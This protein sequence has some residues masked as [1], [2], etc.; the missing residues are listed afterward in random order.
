MI[1]CFIFRE[2]PNF[3]SAS[4]SAT[5]L[6]SSSFASHC[7]FFFFRFEG[8]QRISCSSSFARPLFCLFKIKENAKKSSSQTIVSVVL[9]TL[10]VLRSFLLLIFSLAPHL[11]ARP[12]FFL[13]TLFK[14]KKENAKSLLSKQLSVGPSPWQSFDH[15]SC[16]SFFPVSSLGKKPERKRQR[17][18][19][20]LRCP[21]FARFLFVAVIFKIKKTRANSRTEKIN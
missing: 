18:R 9:M 15:S 16:S 12:L 2:R 14:I 3:F 1:G 7:F 8:P 11:F 10:A 19:Q 17:R 21:P 13:F 4:L 5:F 6:P 20:H